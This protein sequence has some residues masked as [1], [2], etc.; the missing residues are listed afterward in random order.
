M[1]LSYKPQ[2]QAVRLAEKILGMKVN[3]L[4]V[5]DAL[6][7]ETTTYR[8]RMDSVL[9]GSEE[10]ILRYSS[11]DAISDED[12]EAAEQRRDTI[13]NAQ[14]QLAELDGSL[15]NGILSI[16]HHIDGKILSTLHAP[17]LLSEEDSRVERHAALA[18]VIDIASWQ[19]MALLDFDEYADVEFLL[20]AQE[21]VYDTLQLTRK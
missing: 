6:D 1:T 9:E 8:E 7:E 17:S 19:A 12:L 10:T 15:R 11:D 21:I 2:E 16:E 4:A 18:K 13:G 3:V 5:L 14:E 20:Q